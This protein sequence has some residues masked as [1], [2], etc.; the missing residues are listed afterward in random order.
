[1]GGDKFLLL[2]RLDP[3]ITRKF[4]R[5]VNREEIA[6]GYAA[7]PIYKAT[8]VKVFDASFD[9]KNCR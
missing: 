7:S 6:K 5:K 3:Q 8:D 2:S 1:M 9:V 4:I